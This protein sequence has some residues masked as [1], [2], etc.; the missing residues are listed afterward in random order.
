M[1][2]MITIT[3]IRT[4]VMERPGSVL[5][6]KKLLVPDPEYQELWDQVA[7]YIRKHV[8]VQMPIIH[9]TQKNINPY[10][11]YFGSHF[12][13]L[14][15]EPSHFHLGIDVTG[16]IKTPVYPILPGILEYAG[17]HP[18]NGNYV[19]I[20]HPDIVS[21]DGFMLYTLYMHLRDTSVGF[22]KYQKMLREISMR[23]HPQIPISMSQQIGTVGD[24]G[25]GR[26]LHPHVHVQCEFRHKDGTII[27][28]DPAPLLGLASCENITASLKTE[29]A[30]LDMYAKDRQNICE[31][32][33]EKYWK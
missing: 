20:S 19:M 23:T 32:C 28:F 29:S 14:L 22:N 30:F 10:F 16:T 26:G 12:H 4:A 7:I 21:E 24:S 25:D 15:R 8:S 11:G 5:T 31:H 2:V 3:D 33:V 6:K 13:P 18:G 17:F 1:S 27:V 9:A